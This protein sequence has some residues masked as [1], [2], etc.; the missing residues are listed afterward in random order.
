MTEDFQNYGKSVY[1]KKIYHCSHIE[2]ILE[3]KDEI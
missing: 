3:K 1:E 2:N